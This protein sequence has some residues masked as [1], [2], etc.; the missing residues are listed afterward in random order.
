[1]TKVVTVG[2]SPRSLSRKKVARRCWSCTSSIPRRKL[3][4]LPAPGRRMRWSRRSRNWTSFSSP[5]ARA[6]D[7]HEVVDLAVGRLALHYAEENPDEV[8]AALDDKTE[9]VCRELEARHKEARRSLRRRRDRARGPPTLPRED[10]PGSHVLARTSQHRAGRERGTPDASVPAA[11][12]NLARDR[13]D[14][15]DVIYG[16]Y[17]R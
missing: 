13:Q 4:T 10:V 16:R 8:L 11:G 15:A 5:W 2:L 7:G 12:G 1:M 3:S 6:W 17:G 9:A 14:E